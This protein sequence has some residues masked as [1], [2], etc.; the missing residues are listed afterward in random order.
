MWFKE[1]IPV[2]IDTKGRRKWADGKMGVIKEIYPNRGYEEDNSL[3]T[4]LLVTVDGMD[5]R[6]PPF[7]LVTVAEWEI[8]PVLSKAE[9]EETKRTDDPVNHPSHYTDGKYEC[10]DFIESQGYNKDGYLFNA[11]K[12]ISRAG[13]KD[14]TKRKEDL[15]KAIWYL[16]RKLEYESASQH[17][18]IPIVEYVRDKGLE[19]TLPGLA[20]RLIGAQNYSL[21]AET[22]RIELNTHEEHSS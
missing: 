1:G 17:P 14:P 19:G 7:G 20:L 9:T 3:H 8:E 11:V 13:K 12:Y 22:L 21:A 6:T 15:E 10:I 16:E 4:E 2:T 18:Y 5:P